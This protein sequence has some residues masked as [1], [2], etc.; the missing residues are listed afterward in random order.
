MHFKKMILPILLTAFCLSISSCVIDDRHPEMSYDGENSDIHGWDNVDGDEVIDWDNVDV[1]T[2]DETDEISS[3]VYSQILF[4]NITDEFASV[5]T[6]VL[7]YKSNGKYF[8]GDQVYK[9]VGKQYDLNP[10]IAKFAIGTG[11]ILVCVV[12]NVVTYGA[13]TP[14]ACFIAG[15][16]EGA[17]TAA[18]KGAAFGAAMGAIKSYITSD[19]NWKDTLYGTAEGASSGYMWGAIFG[20]ISGGLNS[21]YC[22]TGDTLVK[23]DQSLK[24]IDEIQAGDYVYSY[25][26][27]N[28][29]FSYEPVKNT[30]RS[31][32]KDIVEIV[33]SSSAAVRSTL[34]H[35]YYT[36]KGWVEAKDLKLGMEILS[37]ENTYKPIIGVSQKYFEEPI[38]TYNFT[39]EDNH[40]YLVGED[41]LVVHN[42]CNINS[43]YAGKDYKFKKGTELEKKYPDGVHFSKDGYP[44]FERY[45]A[46][47][48]SFDLPSKESLA[49]GT[50]LTGNYNHDFAM[51]NKAAG[52]GNYP[53]STPKGWTWHHSEDMKTLYLIPQDLHRAIRHTGGA[54]LIKALLAALV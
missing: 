4:E 52:F 50:C 28:G 43:E 54:S 38:P 51:A 39:V 44:E 34:N 9:L 2:W 53:N 29:N 46:K 23:T 33:T 3:W 42:R 27:Q 12:L 32:T 22:F 20:A 14:V 35:P 41:E 19:G 15:A 11:V 13:A 21:N 47:K 26:E 49:N 16:A 1:Q 8:D 45:A 10:L 40:T 17:I 31:E 37:S 18:A 6:V 48:V 36:S 24:T 7:D 5:N 25:N 30:T